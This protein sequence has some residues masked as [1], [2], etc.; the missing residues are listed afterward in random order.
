MPRAWKHVYVIYR[1]DKDLW[2]RAATASPE[3]FFAVK[4]VVSTQEE[5]VREVER[6]N[7]LSGDDN[8]TVYGF[9]SAKVYEA[10][11]ATAEPQKS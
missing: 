7:R 3:K 2:K 6:L 9:Q 1:F 10:G 4:Q 8:N 5:A 11:S